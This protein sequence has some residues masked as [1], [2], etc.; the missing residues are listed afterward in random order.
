MTCGQYLTGSGNLP[1]VTVLEQN[2]PN[3]FNPSTTIRFALDQAGPVHLE[4]L[5][6]AGRHVR[7]LASGSRPGGEHEVTWDG[8]DTFGQ[9]MPS[10]VYVYRLT[11]TGVEET[12]KLMLVR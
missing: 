8:R 4:V 7:N 10:G 2:R 9:P 5:D 6:L 1:P 11:A 12:R 3:P